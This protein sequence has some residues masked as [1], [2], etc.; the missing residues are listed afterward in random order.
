MLWL[1]RELHSRREGKECS[2]GATVGEPDVWV[3]WLVRQFRLA[4]GEEVGGG[5][6]GKG[7]GGEKGEREGMKRKDSGRIET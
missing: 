4:V 7:E 5:G 3:S 1:E 2:T 6:K